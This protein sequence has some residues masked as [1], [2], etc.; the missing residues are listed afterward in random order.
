MNKLKKL[1]PAVRTNYLT[2]LG[3]IAAFAILQPLAMRGKLSPTLQ[4]QLVPICA[5]VVMTLSLNLTVG[6]LGELS[7][8]FNRV[9]QSAIT[10]E[11]TEVS[12]GAR[13]Q[14]SVRR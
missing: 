10:Q 4:G 12:A 7:L 5:Y 14:K 6:V 8:E 3:V 2:Y 1:S 11:I 13:A 9:R